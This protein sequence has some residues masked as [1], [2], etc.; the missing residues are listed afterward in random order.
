MGYG[1]FSQKITGIRDIKTPPPPPL[2]GMGLL[3]HSISKTSGTL[4]LI[5]FCLG[6]RNVKLAFDKF[7]DNLFDLSQTDIFVGS[8]VTMEMS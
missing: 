3:N 2:M 7:K 5:F 1:I 4:K 6:W 8:L